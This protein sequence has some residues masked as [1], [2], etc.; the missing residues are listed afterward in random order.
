MFSLFATL[1]AGG[2]LISLGMGRLQETSAKYV[3]L[4]GVLSLALT[5]LVTASA[6]L[7]PAAGSAFPQLGGAVGRLPLFGSA[8][9][10][11]GAVSVIVQAPGATQKPA[12]LRVSAWIGGA[13]GIVSA[14]VAM[15]VSI[16]PD[17]SATAAGG[18]VAPDTPL[19]AAVKVLSLASASLLLGS[20]TVAWLLG[21]AYLTA[22]E[23]TI[24]PLRRFGRVLGATYVLRL[25]LA[26]LVLALIIHHARAS[27]ASLAL[28]LLGERGALPLRGMALLVRWLVGLLVP[29]VFTWMVMD[30][31]RLRST[32]SATGLLYFNSAM[33]YFGE[34]AAQ[35]LLSD[36]GWPL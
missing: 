26:A 6:V 35:Y 14:C 2:M 33:I 23:M 22:T 17:V 25:A 4:V 34:L 30:C 27:G 11:I 12:P 10:G 29:G 7:D 20:V 5:A 28:A 3:R 24:A 9:C 31:I 1:L 16:A 8:L 21:H 18:L 36:M 19:M 32:Q 13:A 15:H